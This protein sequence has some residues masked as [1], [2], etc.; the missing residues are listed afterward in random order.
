MPED[1]SVLSLARA[2][3]DLIEMVRNQIIATHAALSAFPAVIRQIVREE[4]ALHRREI[5][6]V[7]KA[8]NHRAAR[9]DQ[10]IKNVETLISDG[11]AAVS[12]QPGNNLPIE[13]LDISTRLRI[14]FESEKIRTVGQIASRTESYWRSVPSVGKRTLE[15]IKGVLA[16]HG[17]SLRVGR[18]GV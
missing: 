17:F 2:D 7:I 5:E 9:I 14:V 16:A 4:M 1:E 12:G 13:K 3:Y 8:A 15:E 10:S 11:I 6:N 18:N